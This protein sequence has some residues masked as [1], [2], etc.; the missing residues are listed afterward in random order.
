MLSRGRQGW[1]GE[2]N[3]QLAERAPG[4]AGEGQVGVWLKEGRSGPREGGRGPLFVGID[5]DL[6]GGGAGDP[7]PGPPHR[8]W[9][10]RG[11]GG[12][13]TPTGA[14]RGDQRPEQSPATGLTPLSRPLNSTKKG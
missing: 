14:A 1:A 5:L 6:C 13:W 3:Y 9:M 8:D 12:R 4:N 7:P 11:G 2:G 10:G